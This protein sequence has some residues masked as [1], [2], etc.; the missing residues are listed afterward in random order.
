MSPRLAL[1]SALV[2]FAAGCPGTMPPVARPYATPTAAELRAAL[3]ARPRAQAIEAEARAELVPRK[4]QRVKVKVSVWAAR[5]DRLRLEI[6]GPLGSG[7][8]TLVTDGQRF[9]LLDGRQGRLFTGEA[10]GCNVARLVQVELEPAQAVTVLLGELPMEEGDAQVGWDAHEGG[11]EVL[12]IR[13]ADGGEERVWLVAQDRAWDPVRAERRDATGRLVWRVE[14]ADFADVEGKR[15]PGRT[16]VRDERRG[17]EIR[18]RWRDR[19]LEPTL[20][21]EG[22]RLEAAP[23]SAVEEVSCATGRDSGP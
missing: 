18:L 10:R 22:F 13:T 11:R 15:L 14:H 1:L 17:S 4:G 6:A 5:P 16:T 12:T 3:T 7:A 20:R 19:T 21:D 9:S 8:A 2:T 23:G